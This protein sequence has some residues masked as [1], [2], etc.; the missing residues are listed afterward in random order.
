MA[1]LHTSVFV[2]VVFLPGKRGVLKRAWSEV[3]GVAVEMHLKR[4]IMELWVYPTFL[5]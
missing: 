2:C 4:N 1:H 3:E 5:L